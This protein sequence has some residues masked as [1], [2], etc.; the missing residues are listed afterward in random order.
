MKPKILNQSGHRRNGA[1]AKSIEILS[2]CLGAALALMF[3]GECRA[4]LKPAPAAGGPQDDY[5]IL[6]DTR[7]DKQDLSAVFS[8]IVNSEY[9]VNWRSDIK[10][11]G[12]PNR[13]QR[14]YF[15]YLPT[16]F[17][18]EPLGPTNDVGRWKVTLQLESYGAENSI[19]QPAENAVKLSGH[20]V[21]FVTPDVIYDY[22]NG[23]TGMR[24]NFLIQRR[25]GA[26]PLRL[27]LAA[28]LK[29]VK[30]VLD[31][32]GDRA[33]FIETARKREVMRYGDL[34]VWDSK[35]RG[36][37]TFVMGKKVG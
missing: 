32:A 3:A 22:T 10:A 12:S 26:G 11:Y 29:G 4:G 27:V 36:S 33:Y 16:G 17:T 14:L 2:R 28:D 6:N 8:Y 35:G 37:S 15:T 21:Q 7:T 30:M 23:V 1:A 24:Q 34:K 13:K 31:N 20:Q 5:F 19:A 18:A 9:D 25:P